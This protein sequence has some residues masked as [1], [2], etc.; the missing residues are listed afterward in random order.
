MGQYQLKYKPF[1]NSA[2]LIEWPQKIDKNILEDIRRFSDKIESKGLKEIHELNF[3]YS[4]LLIIY[5]SNLISYTDIRQKLK[6]LYEEEEDL[7][8]GGHHNL[9]QIPVCYDLQYGID[10]NYL[11][12]EKNLSIDELINLHSDPVYTVYGIGFLPGFL[13]LGGLVKELH[14]PRRENPRLDVSKGAIAIG[15]TQTGIYPQSTPG[16][17][18]I[19]GRTPVSLFDARNEKPC[20]VSPGDKI[21]FQPITI[22]EFEVIQ[23]AESSEVYELKK[24]LYD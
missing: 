19:L 12:S 7:N 3:V 1:G 20:F 21:K 15:G 23:I 6:L 8:V 2:I 14:I 4:T 18:H 13:Y 9:W 16:G 5:S 17:W 24:E 10:L 11:S 22:A